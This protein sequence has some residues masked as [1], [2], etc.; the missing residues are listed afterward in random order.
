MRELVTI[1]FIG[2]RMSRDWL[3]MLLLLVIPIVLVTVFSIVLGDAPGSDTLL[4]NETVVLLVLAFQLFGGAVTMNYVHGDLFSEY[5]YRL[6]SLPMNTTLYA[7]TI[8]L[9]GILYSIVLGA[10]LIGY[11]T[12]IWDVNWGNFAWSMLV[13]TLMSALS[14]ILCLVF[15]FSVR[16]FKIAERISE[17]Y[18]V[19]LILLAGM[20][21]PMPDNS[22]IHG[23]NEYVNPITLAYSSIDNMRSGLTTEAIVD[24]GLLFGIIVLVSI[25]LFL[26]GRRRMP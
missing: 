18:G 8:M 2:L 11:T 16:N 5:K 20:F 4:R 14:S 25:A 7:F 12:F 22:L 1:R 21:F 6:R 24:S 26:I 17:I 3:T 19:G 10:I 13:I 9:A 15:T 23:F